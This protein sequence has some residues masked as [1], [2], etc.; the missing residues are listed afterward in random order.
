MAFAACFNL[1]DLLLKVVFAHRTGTLSALCGLFP[2]V[3]LHFL[4]EGIKLSSYQSCRFL[5]GLLLTNFAYSVLNAPVTFPYQLL[6]SLTGLVKNGLTLFLYVRNLRFILF[7]TALQFF[8]FLVYVLPFLFPVTLVANDVLKVF[9]ALN[10]VGPY[11]V[12]GLMY[13]LFRQSR[14]ACYLNCKRAS[15]PSYG[16]LKQRAHLMT[17]IKH[18]AVDD[19]VVRIGKMLQVL[20][21]CCNHRPGTTAAELPQNTFGNS[22]SNLRLGAGSELVY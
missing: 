15:G 20:I 3:V 13:H 1:F 2:A 7:Y 18:R 9:V 17:V 12:F 11:N 8:L 10:I 19:T 6:G 5:F 21:V 22:T 14:L 4:P 16:Q